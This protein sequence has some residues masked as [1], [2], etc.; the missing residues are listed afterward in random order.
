MAR[1]IANYIFHMS[2]LG[3]C[4]LILVYN[5]AMTKEHPDRLASQNELAGEYRADRQIKKAVKLLEHMVSVK[6]TVF[7]KDHTS[8][9]R[10][11]HILEYLHAELLAILDQ[12]TSHKGKA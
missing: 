11:A 5:M 4:L 2:W 6:S 10:S 8:R 7:R 3:R 1:I 12:S 9:L